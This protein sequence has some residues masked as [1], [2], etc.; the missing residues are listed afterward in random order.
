MPIG[1]YTF[2]R[3]IVTI[4][5]VAVIVQEYNGEIIPWII[6]FGII[7]IIFNPIIPVYLHDKEIWAV[8]NFIAAILFG[9]K[10][11]NLS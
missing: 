2:L 8:I 9:V 5:A 10:A 11:F 7:A 4:G 3:I 1:Y 6:L